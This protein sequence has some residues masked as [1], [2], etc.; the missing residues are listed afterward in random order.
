MLHKHQRI[1]QKA[2]VDI[3]E[4]ASI[5]DAILLGEAHHSEPLSI[6]P[7][8]RSAIVYATAFGSIATIAAITLG[9]GNSSPQRPTP[10]AAA[11]SQP[12]GTSVIT[13]QSLRPA[14]KAALMR[15]ER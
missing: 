6:S 10:A 2:R 15:A 12:A 13:D 4:P 11:I 8:V 1:T 7:A 3:R 5:T 9:V 14:A